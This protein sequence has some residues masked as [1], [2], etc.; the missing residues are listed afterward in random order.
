DDNGTEDPSDD[1]IAHF[2]SRGPS[3]FDNIDKPDVIAPGV[4]IISCGHE[5][6][7]VKMS[8]TSMA[9]PFTAGVAALMKQQQPDLRPKD[10][11]AII[12]DNAKPIEYLD[13]TAQGAGAVDP[14]ASIDAVSGPRKVKILKLTRHG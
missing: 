13:K 11:K 8:G 6:G 2:S 3:R 7:Y 12:M 14:K 4:D 10:I 1:W 9:T 5:G